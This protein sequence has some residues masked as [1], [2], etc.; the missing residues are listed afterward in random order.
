[1]REA[2]IDRDAAALLLRQ[3]VGVD[4]RQGSDQRRLAV[5]DVTGRAYDNVSH[6]VYG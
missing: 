2:E 4:S 5:V 1:M 3:T 6:W